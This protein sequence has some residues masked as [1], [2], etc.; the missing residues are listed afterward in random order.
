MDGD[1]SKLKPDMMKEA[2][3]IIKKCG[4]L[5]LAVTT[6]GGFLSDRPRNII[7]WRK[8]SDHI[9]EELDNNPSLEKIKKILK[10]SYDGL[11]YHLKSCFLY[12]SIFPEDHDI[13]YRRL[14]RRWTAE[15][16]SRATRNRSNEKEAEEQFTALLN[17]SMIQQSKTIASGKTGFYQVHDLMR[18]I[19]I[20]KSEEENLVLVL[21]D[22]VTSH[23]KD[24]VRHLVVSKRWSREKKNDMQNI[25]DVSHIRSLTVF[26]E[27]RSFFLSKKMRMLRV[28]DLEDAKGLQDPD[29]VP[30][31]KLR[32]LK[33]LSLRRSFGILNLPNS[34][35]NLLNLET[36]DIRGTCVMKLPATIGRLQN[37]KYLYAGILPADEDDIRSSV[38]IST[39]LEE[40]RGYRTD[41][42]GVTIRTFVSYIMLFVTAWLRNLDVCGVK[43][44]RGIG[45]LRSIHTLSIVNI[46][47]GKAL[48]KNLKKLTQLRKLGV[49]GINKNNCKELCSAIAGHGRLQS[50]LLRAEGKVGLEGC[51]DNMSQPPKDLK[52]LQLYGN[53]VTLPEWIKNLEILQKLSLRNTN[54]KADATMEVLGNL[55]MLAILRLQD[56]AILQLQEELQNEQGEENELRN[57]QS[58][59]N[60]LRNE[61]SDENEQSKE[62]ELQNERSEENEQSEENEFR[63]E[64]HFHP[65]CFTSL[66]A[67]EFISWYDLKSVI[68]EQGATP[69]LE[70]LLVD[71]CWS[72][73]QGGF[74]GIESLATLKEVSLQGEYNTKFKEE[75][76]QKLHMNKAKPNLKIL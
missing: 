13:R 63:N 59:E 2:E 37:L 39:I 35:G 21:D 7:E 9:S 62:N 76:Q 22:H 5:P 25:V 24:K 12:L 66:T 3:I 34:F 31:G 10:S 70:V 53:L 20:S 52:S 56:N 32:H 15:G 18:E 30:I 4:R 48:L 73:D 40:Y 51:L 33:Y 44:T 58:E 60:E 26:G 17:K 6:V 55:P 1:E 68:F 57:E 54:L 14:L 29:L 16:Y 75:L 69:K 50:L 36:L 49:S 72:I 67:L 43:V 61:R 64:L 65:R 74:I 28:L 38:L 42:K 41:P 45:R 27:W 23:S 19:I 11:T 46:A 71:H 47:R 8:F